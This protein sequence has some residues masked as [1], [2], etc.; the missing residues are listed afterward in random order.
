MFQISPDL[1]LSPARRGWDSVQDSVRHHVFLWAQKNL[2]SAI[3]QILLSHSPQY[4]DV[5]VAFLRFY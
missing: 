4:G 2:K 1:F 5:Q 3:M